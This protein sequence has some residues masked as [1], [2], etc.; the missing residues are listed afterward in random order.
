MLS[1]SNAVSKSVKS[2][3][4]GFLLTPLKRISC[5]LPD[6]EWSWFIKFNPYDSY[7]AEVSLLQVSFSSLESFYESIEERNAL[8]N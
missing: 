1:F 7:C 5:T 8:S 3:R 4:F 6:L 2:M